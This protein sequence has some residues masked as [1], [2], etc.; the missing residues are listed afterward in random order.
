[1]TDRRYLRTEKLLITA[2]LALIQQKP[3]HELT[4]VDIAAKADIARKTF[5]NHFTSKTDLL[6]HSMEAHFQQIAEATGDLDPE[7]LLMDDKPLSYP[8]FAHVYDFQLFYTHMLGDQGDGVFVLR[9]MT[10]ITAQSMAKHHVL[11]DAAPYMTIPKE[12]I[13]HMLAGAL[14]GA[15]RWWVETDFIETPAQ[16]AYRYSQLVA[17]G[18]LQSMGLD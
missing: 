15:L 13:A 1:M 14:V 16:M 6:W 3:F 4:V 18:V 9:L 2:M 8:V 11:R 5:Y 17:P 12:Q 7:T 10:Y